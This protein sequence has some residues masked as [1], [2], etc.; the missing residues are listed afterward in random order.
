LPRDRPQRH[1]PLPPRH[2]VRMLRRRR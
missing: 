1:E 2:A